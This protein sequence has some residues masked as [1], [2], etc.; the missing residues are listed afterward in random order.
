MF[1]VLSDVFACHAA[2]TAGHAAELPARRPFR[3]YLEWLAGQDQPAAEAHWRRSLAGFD[4]PTPLPYDRPPAR[5]HDT[6]SAQRLAFELPA[7]VSDRVREVAQHNDL[8][9]NTIIQGAWALLLSRY[10][11][12]SD[13]CFGATVSGRPADLPGADQITGI[14]I[15]TLPVRARL[16]RD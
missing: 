16:N 8:T 12:Q 6:R 10:S 11:G 13:M 4:T 9:V 1:Q 5:A 14:F 3:D 2:L 15:N 7:G